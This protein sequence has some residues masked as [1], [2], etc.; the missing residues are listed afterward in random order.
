MRRAH[1]HKVRR[2]RPRLHGQTLGSHC[3]QGTQFALPLG[4][5]LCHHGCV[6]IAS[7]YAGK[8]GGLAQHV[9]RIDLAN[10][11]EH[12]DDLG[13]RNHIAQTRAGG[14]KRLGQRMQNH[15]VGILGDK[16]LRR[17]SRA[18]RIIGKLNVGLVDHDH[19]GARIAQGRDKVERRHIARGV[20]GRGH[21]RQI[22]LGRRRKHRRLVERK[23]AGSR[24]TSRTSV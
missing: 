1:E 22:A 10:R 21:D 24:H 13:R 4:C 19:A 20:I 15:Q 14:A 8:R 5:N 12:V 9:N 18:K 23:V 17:G 16:P 6:R 7:T 2:A 3:V 11:R